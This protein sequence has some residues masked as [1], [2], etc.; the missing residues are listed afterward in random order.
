MS[1]QVRLIAAAALIAG[2]TALAFFS[3]GFFDRPRLIAGIGAWALAV[4]AAL[5][6]PAPLPRSAPARAALSGLALLAAWTALSYEWAPLGARAQDDVQRLLLYLGFFGASVALLRELVLRRALEGA[7]ALGTVVVTAYGLSGRLLPGLI[8]LDRSNAADGRLEQPLTYWNALGCLASI[9][10]VLCVRIAA[11]GRHGRALR[12]GAGFAAPVLGLGV[13]LS[14]SRGSLF[15][16]AAGLVLLVMLAPS[17]RSQL[18]SAAVLLGA[19]A[20]ACLVATRFP[21]VETLA[22]AQ[23]GDSGD[24]LV[25]LAALLVLG[26]GA[27]LLTARARPDPAAAAAPLVRR[28]AAAIGVVAIVLAG[29]A[30]AAFVEKNPAA[31]PGAGATSPTRFATTDSTRYAYW[32]VGIDAFAENPLKGTGTGGFA[33]EWRRQPDREERAVDAHSLYV[34]TLAELGL[35]G[36]AFLILF[37]G[38][39]AV[40]AVRLHRA[41]PALAA[42][43]AAGLLVWAAHAGLDW[44]WE[45]PAVTGVALLLAAALVAWSDEEAARGTPPPRQARTPAPPPPA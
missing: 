23:G 33:V 24:G 8:D 38:G 26:A 18:Q 22:P 34:E 10:L 11:D 39:V 16:L 35:P 44:D 30:V 40:C 5:T 20:V 1:A 9:G 43:P 13:Y 17:A 4:V 29:V 19:S 32:E 3:G 27:A 45:M 41:A 12:A 15:A 6:S 37:L 31:R 14:F 25:M 2:P 42:G 7:V 21:R 28:P 36:A